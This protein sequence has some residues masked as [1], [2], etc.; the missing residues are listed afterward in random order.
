MKALSREEK[1]RELHELADD[2]GDAPPKRDALPQLLLLRGM[3]L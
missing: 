1:R 2:S 3:R